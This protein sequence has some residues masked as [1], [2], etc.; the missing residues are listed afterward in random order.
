M[1]DV[2]TVPGPP[3]RAYPGPRDGGRPAR[4][5]RVAV[6]TVVLVHGAAA[7]S[8][9]FAPVVARL[10]REGIRVV[11]PAVPGRGLIDDAAHVAAVVSEVDGPVVLVG[12]AYGGAVITVA[13]VEP[14]VVGLVYLAGGALAEGESLVDLSRAAGVEPAQVVAGS[15]CPRSAAAFTERAPVAAW[16]SR[17]AWGLVSSADRAVDPGLARFGYVRAGMTVCEIESSRRIGP[18][19]PNAVCEIV[20]EAVRATSA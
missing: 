2:L 7:G 8:S 19:H 17:P 4:R 14:T 1:T 18:A 5:Q 20:R 12:H 10:L 9:P 15:R 16:R 6:P 13:G 11:E 3:A